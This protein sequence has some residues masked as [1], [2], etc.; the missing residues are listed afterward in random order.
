MPME[1]FGVGQQA[2]QEQEERIEK[3]PTAERLR[4][5]A[6]KIAQFHDEYLALMPSALEE[7]KVIWG[8]YAEVL[9]KLDSPFGARPEEFMSVEDAQRYKELEMQG[10]QMDHRLKVLIAEAVDVV[11]QDPEAQ[12]DLTTASEPGSLA[13]SNERDFSVP[14]NDLY[15]LEV[16]WRNFPTDYPLDS[17]SMYR[18]SYSASIKSQRMVERKKKDIG[19]T[20]KWRLFSRKPTLGQSTNANRAAL[21]F[22][23]IGVAADEKGHFEPKNNTEQQLIELGNRLR[24]QFEGILPRDVRSKQ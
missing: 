16:V 11:S 12:W 21:P 5:L 23:V 22:A 6:G 17:S 9:K 24:E 14:L 4:D 3:V 2:P 13:S 20:K 19:E 15:T 1:K 8:K 7:K 10:D 18:H